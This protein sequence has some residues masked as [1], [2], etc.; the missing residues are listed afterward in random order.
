MVK[1]AMKGAGIAVLTTFAMTVNVSG[2]EA[3]LP[4][5]TGAEFANITDRYPHNIMGGLHAHT[6]LIVDLQACLGCDALPDRLAIRLP[7]NLVF[8]DFAPRLVDMDNDGRNEIVVVESDQQKGAR[9]ALWEVIM[10]QGKAKLVRGAATEFIGTRFRWL[11][12]I[13]AA[14]FDGDGA[15]EFAYVEKPHLDRI[16]RLVRRDGSRLRQVAKVNGVTNHAIGQEDVQSRIEICKDGPQIIA[17]E[18]GGRRML[19]IRFDLR[20]AEVTDIGEAPARHQIGDGQ[21]CDP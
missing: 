11:A 21:Y 13:G 2:Q 3:S 6:D 4:Q 8:E 12:P 15:I 9:L 1:I 7:D 5:P 17:L 16:L 19:A 14:D 10:D 20:S 18:P